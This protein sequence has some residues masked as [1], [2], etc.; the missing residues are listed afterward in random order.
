MSDIKSIAFAL[1]PTN[2]PSF[3]LDWELT[4]RCN[5]DCSYCLTGIEEGGHDNTV[6][7]P[8]LEECLSTIDF[9]FA[10]VDKYMS[11]K[12]PR[13]RKVVLNVYGGESL[14]HPDIVEILTECKERYKKYQDKW[15][16]TL[17]CTTNAI[18]G[19]N[20]WSKIAALIDNFTLSYHTETTVK[21][22]N[23]FKANVHKLKEL[24]IPFRIVMLM[25]NNPENWQECVDT[26]EYFKQQGMQCDPRALDTSSEERW[27]YSPEQISTFKTIWIKK[28][29]TKQQQ[30]YSELVAG[31][32]AGKDK[33]NALDE[34]RACCGNRKLSL[35]GDLK[36]NV[37]FVP[38]QGFKDWHCSVNWFFLFVRQVTGN[39]YTN[40]DCMMNLKGEVGP[41]GNVNNSSAILDELETQ[42]STKS[43]PVIQCAK[44][45]CKCGYCAPK[46]ENKNDFDDLISRHIIDNPLKIN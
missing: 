12:K 24:N 35:N 13:Q 14:F 31:V 20:Q 32:G 2:T 11:Y 22:K 8:A 18:V 16:L 5:L 42:L 28:A 6:D 46:A 3:L 27:G 36:S 23:I 39:V 41:I 21:Q 44:S 17:H 33:V 25:H 37:V 19:V 15:H 30:E 29:P 1:E 7:H 45:F 40:K 26:M 43:L 34:G 9:M 10:Y 4:K 38:R